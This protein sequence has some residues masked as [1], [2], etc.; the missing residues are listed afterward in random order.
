MNA[1]RLKPALIMAVLFGL[2]FWSLEYSKSKKAEYDA[3]HSSSS[4]LI[5]S[6]SSAEALSSVAVDS[7]TQ[8]SKT[9]TSATDSAKVQSIAPKTITI[10]TDH[11]VVQLS[12]QGAKISSLVYLGLKDSKGNNPELLQNANLGAL[13]FKI[14]NQDFSQ[15]FFAVQNASQD[16]LVLTGDQSFEL[17]F[18]WQN[19]TQSI[20]RSFTFKGNTFEIPVSLK[21]QGFESN[22]PV[23]IAWNGGM[24]ETDAEK[25][26]REGFIGTDYFFSE[27]IFFDGSDVSREHV[28]DKKSFN[29]EHGQIQWA[30]MRRKYVAGVLD[31]GKAM[32]GVLHYESLATNDNNK[33]IKPSYKLNVEDKLSAGNYDFKFVLLPL[34]YHNLKSYNREYQDILWSG[35]GWFF[36]ADYWFPK[37]CGL[38]LKLLNIFYSWLGNYGLA[39]ML[40]TLVVRGITTPLTLSQLRSTRL[41]QEHKPALDKIKEQFGKDPRR[42]QE[43][44]MSYYRSNGINPFAP[45]L[46]C[47][48]VLFQM[49]IFIALF[50]V[51]ARAVE[52]RDAHFV[53][54]IVDLSSPDIITTAIKIPWIMPAGLS[55]LPFIMAISS[56]YQTKQTITDPN[57][58]MMVWMMPTMMFVFSGLMPSGLVIY[59][60]ISNVYSIAQY[61]LIQTPKVNADAALVQGKQNFQKSKKKK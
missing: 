46:G 60:I 15:Q 61:M 52:L 58:K 27:A 25:V 29:E 4:S 6:S 45:M 43:E 32:E 39:I 54:W 53:S 50:V 49:P 21:T 1:S 59:W 17:Q 44:V 31:F 51:L 47:F 37:L 36:G 14:A 26:H 2:F 10:K 38:T 18:L 42:Y 56:W 55:I 23:Q 34:E 35:F 11:Y 12:N 8:N 30:G 3:Q 19:G 40:L 9:D 57:M 20:T 41:L 5:A 24:K 13:D 33:N 7:A 22:S 16:T 28:T 48:P